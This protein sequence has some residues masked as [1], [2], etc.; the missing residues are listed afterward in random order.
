MTDEWQKRG[1]ENRDY[2][3]LTSEISKATFGLTPS[4]YKK[5]KG[6]ERQNL[7]DHMDDFELI[8]TML[9]ERSTTEIHR[10]E[11][12][13]GKEKLKKDAKRG[14]RI[15]GIARTELEKEIGRKVV[16]KKNFL[17]KNPPT[18]QIIDSE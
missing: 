15:A 16:S 4:E 11:D 13:K 14:G 17:P 8:F 5:V 12:S 7:R 9:G 3:I 1:A 6:L 2:E 18:K 10:T